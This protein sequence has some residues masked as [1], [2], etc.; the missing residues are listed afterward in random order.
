VKVFFF[1]K[2]L[3]SEIGKLDLE[4]FKIFLSSFIDEIG[5]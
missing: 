4:I 5:D 1:A 2:E 3:D